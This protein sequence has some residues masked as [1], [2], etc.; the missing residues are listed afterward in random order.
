M[1]EIDYR[2]PTLNFGSIDPSPCE[3]PWHR[4]NLTL[5]VYAIATRIGKGVADGKCGPR[6]SSLA[7]LWTYA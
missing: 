4:I 6:K 1:Y 3:F 2:S 7:R 5:A